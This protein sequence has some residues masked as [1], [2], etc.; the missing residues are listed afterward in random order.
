MWTLEEQYDIILKRGI[1]NLGRSNRLPCLVFS[2]ISLHFHKP[3][4]AQ[5]IPSIAGV[6]AV[7]HIYAHVYF[8][9]MYPTAPNSRFANST[10]HRQ[11]RGIL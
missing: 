1:V 8:V 11:S 5:Y 7:P 10:V 4:S 3:I 6:S 2:G 9:D